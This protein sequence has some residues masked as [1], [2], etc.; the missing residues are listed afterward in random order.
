MTNRFLLLFW[1]FPVFLSA[2]S[3]IEPL[4][5]FGSTLDSIRKNTHFVIEKLASSSAW[6]VHEYDAQD[7]IM[8]IGTF[9]DEKLTIASGR[10]KYYN[11]SPPHIQITYDY[12]THKTDSVIVPA[13]NFLS[14][15]GYYVNGEKTG[16]WTTFNASKEK[17]F[18]ETLEHGKMNGLYES[19]NHGIVSVRGNYVD[20]M[21]EGE[22]HIL[23]G[24]GDTMLTEIY[25]K[26]KVIK[27]IDFIKNK[28]SHVTNP[29]SKYDFIRYLNA[30]LSKKGISQSGTKKSFYNIT[31]DTAGRII[32][33]SVITRNIVDE[34]I[35]FEVDKAIIDAMLNAPD[36]F[37]QNKIK[38]RS[39]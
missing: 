13:K 34:D 6:M 35:N 22:W 32:E 21:R 25:K 30:Q 24:K 26:N 20:D 7:S 8:T 3:R 9:L 16:I 19:Y 36:G 10:F 5:P 29:R 4:P 27:K 17:L 23:S 11:Y 18:V 2:Q 1:L 28:Y 12:V 31:I 15:V 33:P 37:R 39:R 14:K 38:R